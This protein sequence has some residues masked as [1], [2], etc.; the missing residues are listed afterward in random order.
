M[1]TMTFES[2]KFN[3]EMDDKMFA[4]PPKKETPPSGEDK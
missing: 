1:M 2:Y 3:E 4:M